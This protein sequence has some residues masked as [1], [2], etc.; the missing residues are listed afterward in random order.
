MANQELMERDSASE[1]SI[2]HVAQLRSV[3][4]GQ[5]AIHGI[6]GRVLEKLENKS[7]QETGN[8]FVYN[9]AEENPGR[10]INLICKMT[11]SLQ[12][13]SGMQGD[14]TLTINNNLI[15]TSLDD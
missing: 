13:L 12:P 6:F 4:E 11:P 10:F 2:D 9:W 3:L 1:L 7:M 5:H 14:I 15:Q 8:G